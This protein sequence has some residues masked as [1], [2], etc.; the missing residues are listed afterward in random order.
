[1]LFLG[2]YYGTLAAA[3]CL[4]SFGVDT[5][6][7]EDNGKTRTSASK[8]LS[9]SVTA[10]SIENA[11]AFL[12]WL[13]AQG[14]R[15][16]GRVLF[17][18]SD[19]L[20]FLF[21]KEWAR[22]SPFYRIY[23]PGFDTIYRIINKHRLY[24][25]CAK[26]NVDFP[27]TWF[28]R[29]E[30]ELREVMQQVHVPVILKPK[31]QVQLRTGA[32][33]GEIPKGVAIETAFA[34][35]IRENPYGPELIAHDSEVVWPM[36]QEF[37]P[38]GAHHIYSLAGFA[39]GTDRLPM[40]RASR[41]I[42]QRPRKLGIGLC[43]ESAPLRDEL[44]QAVGRLCQELGYHGMFEIEFIEHEGKELLID[45]NPRGYSQMAFE[46][47]RDLPLPWLNY[48]RAVGN[49]AAFETARTKAETWSAAPQEHVYA[50]G[51]LLGIV[52]AGQAL[53]RLV[54]KKSE[55]WGR[56]RREHAGKY[57]DAVRFPGDMGPVLVDAE[58][59]MR[60]AIKHPRSFVK[61]FTR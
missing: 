9:S 37:L 8:F 43:F 22:L 41:K 28:P 33:A 51:T 3:R 39:D 1:M 42:L 21:A 58:K 36:L 50:H 17:P 44:R 29:G 53:A 20:V 47:A 5:V 52:E 10:P 23:M 49:D 24:E 12:D 6:L 60:A 7:V 15:F 31:T 13:I 32:K 16:A 56:W 26:V 38:K 35:F 30:G 45:F 11:S 19:E 55:H 48:T 18:A 4:G 54:G 2:D 25:A 46:V 59:H 34:A 40:A 61:S 27:K 14:P 57:T